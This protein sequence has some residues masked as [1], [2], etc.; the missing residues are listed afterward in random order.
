MNNFEDC[1][2][3]GNQGWTHDDLSSAM[4]GRYW[5]YCDCEYADRLGEKDD[6]VHLEKEKQ[7]AALL[8]QTAIEETKRRGL[9][10]SATCKYCKEVFL[11]QEL[12]DILAHSEVCEGRQN[13]GKE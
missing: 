4:G 5:R 11:K 10:L 2:K 12:E 13:D 7:T 6:E 3:C 9:V 1:D 8:L